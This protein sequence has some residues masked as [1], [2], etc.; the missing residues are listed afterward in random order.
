M[1]QELAAALAATV[2]ELFDVHVAVVLTR[3]EPQFGD[4]ATNVALQLAKQLGKNPREVAEQVSATLKE[5]LGD[6]VSSLSIAGPGFINLP[7]SDLALQS[8]VSAQPAKALTGKT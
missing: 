3:P 2:T 4:F 5:K 6:K 1:K 8:M 7:L